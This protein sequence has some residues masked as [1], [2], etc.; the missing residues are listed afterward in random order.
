MSDYKNKYLKYKKKYLDLKKI[1]GGAFNTIINLVAIPI[2]KHIELVSEYEQNAVV[3]K[4]NLLQMNERINLKKINDDSKDMYQQA[5]EHNRF[6]ETSFVELYDTIGLLFNFTIIINGIW[7]ELA[8]EVKLNIAIFNG[9]ISAFKNLRDEHYIKGVNILYG[10]MTDIKANA[11][12]TPKNNADGKYF[13]GFKGYVHAYGNSIYV[14]GDRRLEIKIHEFI[15]EYEK[16]PDEYPINKIIKIFF[17]KFKH[18]EEIGCRNCDVIN[19]TK[20]KQKLLK[21]KPKIDLCDQFTGKDH[22]F[23]SDF[24]NSCKIVECKPDTDFENYIRD[25]IKIINDKEAAKLEATRI[26]KEWVK[27]RFILTRNTNIN[28][29]TTET[30]ITQEYKNYFRESD[31]QNKLG[32]I[33]LLDTINNYLKVDDINLR[34][35]I[36]K[37]KDRESKY[38]KFMYYDSSGEH[39]FAYYDE[40]LINIDDDG[41][42]IEYEEVYKDE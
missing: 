15:C 35:F 27:N 23:N 37:R 25:N 6:E 20:I 24:Y 42:E 31:L 1:L 41:T 26:D 8:N 9:D 11:L 30:D 12:N 13:I 32:R 34:I 21:L 4:N 10:C 28:E 3:Y 38:F 19:L 14:C 18:C 7:N 29:E 36:I 39:L 33:I 16:Y 2:N 40:N 22:Y 5:K 17:S